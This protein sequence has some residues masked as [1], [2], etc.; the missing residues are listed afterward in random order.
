MYKE[1]ELFMECSQVP[2]GDAPYAMGTYTFVRYAAR[3][4][5][6]VIIRDVSGGE[7]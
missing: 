4:G 6:T 5:A 2:G 7:R 3:S 1:G